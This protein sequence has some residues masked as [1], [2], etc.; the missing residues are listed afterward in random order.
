MHLFVT[1]LHVLLASFL[2]LVILLQPGK[3]GSA[4]F[5]GGGGN[6]NYGPRGKAHVLSQVT[7]VAAALFMVTSIT[8]AW[9]SNHRNK[10]GTDIEDD[11]QRLEAEQ[12]ALLSSDPVNT[13]GTVPV[14]PA[15]S[16]TVAPDAAPDVTGTEPGEE[17]TPPATDASGSPAAAPVVGSNPTD[18]A[19]PTSP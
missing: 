2:I 9:W 16:E 18:Q 1:V 11:I 12:G 3:E 13:L 19:A 17:G 4:A 10:S 7:G 8:L 5:G 15:P 6:Q 14:E